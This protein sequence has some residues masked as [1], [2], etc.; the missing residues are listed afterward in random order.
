VIYLK[1]C[2][3]YRI[4]PTPKQ[5]T[6]L[7]DLGFYAT[8]LYNT[9]NYKRRE[10]W[11][12]TGEIPSWYEQKK[13]LRKNHWYQLLPSQTAQ[14]VCKELQEAYNSWYRLRKTDDKAHPPGFRPKEKL[15]PLIFYQ[16][17]KLDGDTIRFSMSRKYRKE[18]GI[19]K[20]QFKLTLWREIEGIAKMATIL[21]RD[22]KWMVH[23]VYEVE[24]PPYTS[25][26]GIMGV[27][28]GIV[29]LA[30]TVDTNG[31]STIY[32][33]GQALAVQHYFNKEIARVQ[34]ATMEQHGKKTSKA[35]GRMHR[36]KKQQVNQILHTT[37]KSVVEEA[38]KNKVGTIVIGDIK[39][40]RKGKHW[41]KKSGQKLHS[42]SFNKLTKQ[43]THKA[44]LSGIRV[45]KVSEQYT[46]QTCS[47][48]GTKRKSNRKHRG[49]YVCKNCNT[50]LNADQNGARN[51]LK[52][53]LRDN[54]LSKSIGAVAVPSIWR[55][56]NVC[57]T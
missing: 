57:P 42:W 5:E 41:N 46:S 55:S 11:K 40:I 7:C 25:D 22:G 50:T 8:K 32:S 26:D 48:C 12:E 9:D 21:Y 1:Q 17:F 43:I 2:I 53:Y 10:A 36:K 38:K 18:T 30:T 16:Q 13:L 52:K 14:R 29:N 3:K 24:E 47:V 31:N 33:G 37:S 51:I 54:N 45:E 35:I 6:T 56:T 4:Y 20:L 28:L 27:D 23:V 39:N 19:K 49:L 34:R 44:R 15:S